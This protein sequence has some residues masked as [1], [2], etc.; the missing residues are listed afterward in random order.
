MRESVYYV[1]RRIFLLL[2]WKVIVEIID[3]MG[4]FLEFRRLFATSKYSD[5]AIIDIEYISETM[6]ICKTP[7]IIDV[8]EITFSVTVFII[9]DSFLIVKHKMR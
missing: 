1:K 7:T 5:N 6:M 2:N 4:D 3:N 8:D 9:P